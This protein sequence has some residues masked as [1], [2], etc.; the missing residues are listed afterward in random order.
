MK[1]FLSMLLAVGGLF[2]VSGCGT[3][4][5]SPQ[6]RDLAIDRNMHY[7]GGQIIDDFDHMF[8]LRPSS[9]LTWWNVQ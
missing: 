2:L 6:E 5:L 3:P 8:L 9:R 1:M 7:E 4:G